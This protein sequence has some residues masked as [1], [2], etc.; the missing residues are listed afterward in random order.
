MG[1]LSILL[2][3]LPA[4]KDAMFGGL[5]LSFYLKRNKVIT[6][7]CIALT[8]TAF[9]LFYLFEQAVM[10]G[11]MSKKLSEQK[12]SPVLVNTNK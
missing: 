9:G 5:K 7:L 6:M 3:L 11:H 12:C 10:H 1:K 4:I 8:I 2:K